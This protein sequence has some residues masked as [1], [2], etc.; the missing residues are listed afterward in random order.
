MGTQECHGFR[1]LESVLCKDKMMG[2][3]EQETATEGDTSQTF[4]YVL[5]RIA[6]YVEHDRLWPVIEIVLSV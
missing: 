6:G 2:L 1:V 3:R 5:N 4:L